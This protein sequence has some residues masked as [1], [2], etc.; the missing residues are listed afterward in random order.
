M[1]TLT[2]GQ[3][4]I[5]KSDSAIKT[6][7]V[8]FPNG[9]HADLSN[10]D[11]VLGSVRFKESV[12][13]EQN[14]RFGCAEASVIEFEAIGLPNVYGVTIECS[15]TFTLENDSVTI[16]FGR[17]VINSCPRSAGAMYRRKIQAYTFGGKQLEP[18]DYVRHLV[19]SPAFTKPLKLNL[20]A[21]M[22]AATNYD[23]G[24]NPTAYTPLPLT[25]SG[26]IITT[27]TWTVNGHTYTLSVTGS[28]KYGA[29]LP[30]AYKL[31][32]ESVNY[33]VYQE[34]FAK[35][36]ELE[37]TNIAM[38][39]AKNKVLA[40]YDIVNGNNRQQWYFSEPIDSN[41]DSGYFFGPSNALDVYVFLPDAQTAAITEDGVTI[42]TFSLSG[43]LTNAAITPYNITDA[44]LSNLIIQI[45]P[46][47]QDEITTTYMYLGAVDF[48]NL[49]DGFLE[50]LGSFGSVDRYG[51]VKRVTL[52]KNNPVNISMA[53]YVRD[54]F[55][56]DEY[57]VEP[58]GT[59]RYTYYDPVLETE[60]TVEH[61][62]GGG[63]SVYDMTSN[64]LLK[65]LAIPSNDTLGQT[66]S[67]RIDYLLDTYFTPAVQDIDFI[68]VDITMIGMPYLEAGDYLVFDVGDATVGTY[69]MARTLSGV[70]L[71]DD[72][73]STGGEIINEDV[74]SV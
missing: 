30:R 19:N 44:Y 11:I 42:E 68:P 62:I 28:Y 37:I 13:S 57:T 53:E 14:L 25:T 3:Q 50:L 7:H 34:L 73:Q 29:L 41:Y 67:E 66:I 24:I 49:Y 33:T 32:A 20:M 74:K 4:A 64:A 2:A 63:L 48:P 70:A 47:F 40:G 55:W 39:N 65:L 8:H 71:M 5:V 61:S 12:C 6:F 31:T 51:A 38:K 58:I 16:P 43:F 35:L 54:G 27:P 21:F 23:F 26:R 60:Q 18:S 52:S 9:E 46:S 22:M 17:F 56:W 36:E 1:I 10:N 15:M 69:M 59:V 45:E 72:I